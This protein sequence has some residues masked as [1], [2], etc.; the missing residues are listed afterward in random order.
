M[1]ATQSRERTQQLYEA[2][3]NNRDDLNKNIQPAIEKALEDIEGVAMKNKVTK[4]IV[5]AVAK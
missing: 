3:S 4:Q 2:A 5:E 1:K